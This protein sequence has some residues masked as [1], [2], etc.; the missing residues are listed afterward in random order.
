M[1][2]LALESLVRLLTMFFSDLLLYPNFLIVSV[3]AAACLFSKL[4]GEVVNIYV[5]S[6]FN[7][8][9]IIGYL[10]ELMTM[11]SSNVIL[12]RFMKSPKSGNLGAERVA[13]SPSCALVIYLGVIILERILKQ[14]PLVYLAISLYLQWLCSGEAFCE[15]FSPRREYFLHVSMTF[16]T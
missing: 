9:E 14:V 7:K 12:S 15:F 10:T 5:L 3:S 8:K 13:S 16:V 1:H 4:I 2:F 11:L 6:K